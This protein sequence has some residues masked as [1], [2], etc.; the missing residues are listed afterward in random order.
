[1]YFFFREDEADEYRVLKRELE[2]YAKNCRVLSFKLKK[3]EKALQETTAEKQQMEQQIKQIGPGRKT[4]GRF[5]AQECLVS[6]VNILESIMQWTQ[7]TKN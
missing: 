5:S 7:L 6:L 3:S 4:L 1:M 2:T